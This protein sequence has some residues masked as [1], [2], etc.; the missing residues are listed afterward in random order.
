[1]YIMGLAKAPRSFRK[2]PMP[3]QWLAMRMSSAMITRMYLALKGTSMP[4]SF[5]AART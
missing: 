2:N 3:M 1:M 4:A 5:S